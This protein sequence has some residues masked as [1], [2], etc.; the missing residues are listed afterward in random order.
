VNKGNYQHSAGSP[1]SICA[2]PNPSKCDP[3]LEAVGRLASGVAHD[4]NNLLT[5]VML[6][7]DLLADEIG[8]SSRR[9][10]DR[11]RLRHATAEIRN[12]CERGTALIQQL[13]VVARPVNSEPASVSWNEANL[14]ISNLLH[15]LLGGNIE[16]V[17]DLAP[18][19]KTVNLSPTRAQQVILNLVLNAR[20]AMPKGG[21][22][23]LQTR[24]HAAAAHNPREFVG[25]SVTDTGCG[26][27]E[28]TLAR[29]FE[30]FFTT[31]PP[32]RGSGIGLATVRQIVNQAGGE[33]QIKS[34]PTSGTCVEVRLP[35]HRIQKLNGAKRSGSP[36]RAPR[37]RRCD[38]ET[39]E[40]RTLPVNSAKFTS[41]ASISLRRQ[42]S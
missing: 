4:F 39:R 10:P 22:I 1:P 2:E 15:R 12:A 3:N 27:D 6:Y 40:A 25:L 14:G 5:G 9:A 36:G 42:L 33:I 38:S 28:K 24:N 11:N 17:A 13:M 41:R 8:H 35:P 30:P 21:K 31:K 7:C 26:M 37:A 32:G 18:Q 34:H 20:D 29:A 19:L 16:F 23:V